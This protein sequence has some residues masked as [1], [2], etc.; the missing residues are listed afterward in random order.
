MQ[1]TKEVNPKK[2][3][4]NL[5]ICAIFSFVIASAFAITILFLTYNGSEQTYAGT[6]FWEFYPHSPDKQFVSRFKDDNIVYICDSTTTNCIKKLKGHSGKI[7]DIDYSSDCKHLA[8]ASDDNTIKIWNIDS[9]KCIQT[10]KGHTK[11][12]NY[13]EYC[14]DGKKLASSSSDGTIKIWDIDSGKCI[15]TIEGYE[16]LWGSAS[17]AF[18]PNGKYL[19]TP[20]SSCEIN[21]LDVNSGKCIQTLKGHVDAILSMDFSPNNKHL[22][23]V[24]WEG[25]MVIW[26][27]ETGLALKTYKDFYYWQTRVK[28]LSD[29]KSFLSQGSNKGGWVT[30]KWNAEV[31]GQGEVIPEKIRDF[32]NSDVIIFLPFFCLFPFLFLAYFSVKGAENYYNI[33]LQNKKDD[34]K[35]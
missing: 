14:S 2:E 19:A 7:N 16:S 26:N 15:Q 4:R 17:I 32:Y 21:I 13:I 8:S 6:Y 22:V 24:D 34:N 11:K 20:Y 30:K 9:G 35:L 25:M 12:V 18:S 28:Y 10:L 31:D 23:S 1:K 3:M 33:Y 27:I 29:G 5:I